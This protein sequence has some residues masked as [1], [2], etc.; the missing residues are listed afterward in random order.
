M[1][2]GEY[3]RARKQAQK[4]QDELER[5]ENGDE[6]SPEIEARAVAITEEIAVLHRGTREFQD[7]RKAR[8]AQS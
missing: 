3:N 2:T 4:L 1:T 5:I 7:A 6:T 8:E